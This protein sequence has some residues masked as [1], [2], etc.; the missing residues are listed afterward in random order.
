[1]SEKFSSGTINPK[2]TN[3]KTD[4]QKHFALLRLLET[5]LYNACFKY[6]NGIITARNLIFSLGILLQ[7]GFHTNKVYKFSKNTSTN[8]RQ[9]MSKNDE[10]SSL[11]VKY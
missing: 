10:K 3:K 9:V 6:Q 4:K 11:T 1:M 5:A 2:Q 7:I 8:V